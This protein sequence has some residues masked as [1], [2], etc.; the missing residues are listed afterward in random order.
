MSCACIVAMQANNTKVK[1]KDKEFF[2]EWQFE[3]LQVN[4]WII[5]FVNRLYEWHKCNQI[6]PSNKQMSKTSRPVNTATQ[7]YNTMD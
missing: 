3:R 2:I 7:L 1:R 6:F 5:F 4:N